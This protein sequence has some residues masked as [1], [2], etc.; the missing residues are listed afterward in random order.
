M[1][2]RLPSELSA[3]WLTPSQHGTRQL[4]LTTAMRQPVRR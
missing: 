3:D 2:G 1:T 4:L